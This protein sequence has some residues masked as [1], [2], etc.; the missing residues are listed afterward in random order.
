MFNVEIRHLTAAQ[1]NFVDTGRSY[2][3]LR[4][5]YELNCAL[6]LIFLYLEE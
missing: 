3:L 5:F 2:G 6:V 4:I 1:V